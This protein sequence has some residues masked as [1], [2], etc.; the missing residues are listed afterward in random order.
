[1][2]R[3]GLKYGIYMKATLKSI[4]M[5]SHQSLSCKRDERRDAAASK[6]WGVDN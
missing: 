3:F 6:V 5:R 4:F 2:S 1:M